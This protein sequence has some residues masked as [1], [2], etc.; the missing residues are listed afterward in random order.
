MSASLA[1]ASISYFTRMPLKPLRT[2]ASIPRMPCRSM[3]ASTVALTDFSL[4]PRF[5][6][7]VAMPAPMQPDRPTSTNSTGV[8]PWSSE[9]KISGWSVS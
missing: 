6:A 3:S 9:A 8:E 4:M 2:S 1:S 7:T 5:A